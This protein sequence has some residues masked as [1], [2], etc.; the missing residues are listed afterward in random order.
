MLYKCFELE[1]FDFLLKPKFVE[2]MK[3]RK[4]EIEESNAIKKE[5]EKIH[6]EHEIENQ[7]VDS[8]SIANTNHFQTFLL[9]QQ[10][11][12]KSDIQE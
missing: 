9:A 3:Q 11:K 4:V 2:L 1:Q 7:K 12:F 10:A 8:H 5:E 6:F